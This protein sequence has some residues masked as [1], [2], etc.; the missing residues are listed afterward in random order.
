MTI[1]FYSLIIALF[2]YNVYWLFDTRNQY[3]FVYRAV[4]FTKPWDW[5][6][7][8]VFIIIMITLVIILPPIVPAFLNFSWLHLL[9]KESTNA[10]V[11]ILYS[12]SDASRWLIL[13][14]WIFFLL[15]LPKLAYQEERIFRHHN[16]RLIHCIFP[17][18][19]FGLMHCI[20]GVPI[21]VGLILG[22]LGF[23]LSL[24]YIHHYKKQGDTAYGL[25]ASTSVHGK[26]NII[27]ITILCLGLI[28][29]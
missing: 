17:N 19:K 18:F 10:N 23:L 22:A 8:I 24:K 20:V 5:L 11:E 9:Q 16:T 26:Y 6:L 14:L 15:I 21:I 27:L 1:I 3:N 12:V 28:L 29:R 4:Y 7:A 25:L 13:P 2:A